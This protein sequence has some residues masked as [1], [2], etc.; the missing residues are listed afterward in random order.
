MRIFVYVV[1]ASCPGAETLAVLFHNEL[2]NIIIGYKQYVM[3]DRATLMTV[4]QQ[5][6]DLIENLVSKM[7][8]LT[9]HHYAAKNRSDI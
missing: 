3:T 9:H 4:T 5:S 6:D 7:P 1:S 8:E 2:N